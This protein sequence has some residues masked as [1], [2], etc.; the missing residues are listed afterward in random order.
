[1]DTNL[2]TVLQAVYLAKAKC[3]VG[4]TQR[5]N[6]TTDIYTM[7]DLCIQE[8]EYQMEQFALAVGA[9][10]ELFLEIN[11]TMRA[12][13]EVNTTVRAKYQQREGV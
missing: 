10:N 8:Y 2:E 4:L 11:N 12:Y 3:L 9:L 5:A 7:G 13:L 6:Q 1:M